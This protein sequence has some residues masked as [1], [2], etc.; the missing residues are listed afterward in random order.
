[1]QAHLINHANLSAHEYCNIS[2]VRRL[3]DIDTGL[4]Q[5][6]ITRLIAALIDFSHDLKSLLTSDE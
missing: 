2:L 6:I 3:Y 4:Q 5:G 1:M